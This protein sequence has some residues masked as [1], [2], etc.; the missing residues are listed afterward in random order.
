MVRIAISNSRLWL[1]QIALRPRPS[2]PA[3]VGKR[4]AVTEAGR[5][6]ALARSITGADRATPGAGSGVVG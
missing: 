1:F 6:A 4:S 5:T 3:V 2:C